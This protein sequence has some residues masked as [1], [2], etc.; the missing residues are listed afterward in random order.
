MTLTKS[1]ST[2]ALD[3][4]MRKLKKE[5]EQ[6]G[7]AWFK[8][9]VVGSGRGFF[10]VQ[11]QILAMPYRTGGVQAK[12]PSNKLSVGTSEYHG[13]FKEKRYNNF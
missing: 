4:K 5:Y 6:A 1:Q 11:G 3:P 7:P 13:Q 10:R 8:D 9:S 2:G 12:A